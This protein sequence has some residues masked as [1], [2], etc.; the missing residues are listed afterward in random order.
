MLDYVDQFFAMPF[1]QFIGVAGFLF[2]I[3]SFALLQFRFIDGNGVLYSLLNILGAAFLL[4][5]LMDA[6]NLA[7]VLIQVSWIVIGL[8][9][10]MLR[11]VSAVSDAKLR[12]QEV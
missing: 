11:A 3:A 5:S 4:V 8:S 10:L 1:T 12:S 6:F 9:G 2:Y 7:S